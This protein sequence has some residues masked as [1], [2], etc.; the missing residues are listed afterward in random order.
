MRG[1]LETLVRGSGDGSDS[2]MDVQ[3]T[4]SSQLTYP[5]RLK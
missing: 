1:S 4:D 3:P 2:Q 5:F